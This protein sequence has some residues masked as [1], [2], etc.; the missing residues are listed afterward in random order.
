MPSPAKAGYSKVVTHDEDEDEHEGN[1]EHSSLPYG[2]WNEAS[3][4]SKWTYS[5][6][7]PIVKRGST[8][9][10]CVD[11]V[12]PTPAP[13][14]MDGLVELMK[15]NCAEKGIFEPKDDKKTLLMT[16]FVPMFFGEYF[17]AWCFN[18]VQQSCEL[19]TPIL[20]RMFIQ[21]HGSGEPLSTGV[22]YS[23]LLFTLAVISSWS[24]ANGG[25][26]NYVSGLKMRASMM[27]LIYEKSTRTTGTGETVGQIVNYMSSDSQRF[28]ESCMM[29]NHMVMTPIWLLLAM[30]QLV[31]LMGVSGLLGTVI[32]IL[33]LVSNK[34]L[35]KSLRKLRTKQ[36]MNTDSRIMLVNEALSGIRVLKQNC[37]EDATVAKI[38]EL[39]N[40]ELGRLKAQER[41]VALIRFSFFSMP[42]LVAVV[43]FGTHALMGAP[44]DAGEVFSA[45]AL[46]TLIQNYLRMMP[47]AMASYNQ[48]FISQ[49]RIKTYLQQPERQV[50]DGERD[51]QPAVDGCGEVTLTDASYTHAAPESDSNSNGSAVLRDISLK[52][53]HGEL[54]AVVGPVGCGKSSLLLAILGELERTSGSQ[55][56]HGSI[57]YCAQQ[58]WILAGT[59]RDNVCFGRPYDAKRFE[60]AIECSGLRPD[61]AQ[62]PAAEFT[63]IGERCV[64]RFR[65][66]LRSSAVFAAIRL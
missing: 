1:D 57:A 33:G 31:S 2:G 15:Q 54:I 59:L 8:Q 14:R 36:M 29:T 18:V 17:K 13:L 56:V 9:Q 41:I 16:V 6:V 52:A 48:L 24:M 64:I 21:W 40:V 20:L 53:A 50:L 49:K 26:K 22:V 61:L 47:R 19:T 45:L 12:P 10:L 34:R 43:T 11:D 38:T 35:W 58:A 30:A 23:F 25:V 4:L 65:P 39:R 27:A 66:E 5:W 51:T 42:V 44:V 46:F 37:W 55:V 63:E 3:Q 28:P 62:L 60:L 7:T 32:M